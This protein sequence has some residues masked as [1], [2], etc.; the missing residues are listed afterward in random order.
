LRA[1]LDS[2]PVITWR[3]AANGYV[4]ELNERY[5]EYTGSTPEEVRGRRWKDYIHPD[6]LEK[7]VNIGIEYV[8]A[9]E[10][11]DS[12]ARIRRF[13]GEYRWFLHRPA[14]VR[15]ETGTIVAWCGAAIDIEELNRAQEA[16]R[17]SEAYSAEA[18]RLSSM[19]VFAADIANDEHFWSDETRR[20]LGY[21][22]DVRP[23]FDLIHQ[24][25]HP[26][27][28]AIFQYE[29]Q[30]STRGD[31]DH[32]YEVRLLMPDGQIKYLHV[33]AQRVEYENGK[34]ELVGALMDITA[35]RQNEHA[36]KE[37]RAALD[38]TPIAVWSSGS[39]GL[40]DFSNK[41]WLAYLGF[42]AGEVLGARWTAALHPD[43]AQSHLAAW[44]ECVENQIPFQ[45]E[46]RF[47]RFD[48]EYRWFLVDAVPHRDANGKVV[49]WHG[50]CIDIEDRK[51]A[52]MALRQSEAQLAA[53]ERESRLTL[54]SIPVITWR[55]A[56][57]GYVQRINK[58][59]FEYTGST[60]DESRGRRWKDYV[61]PDDIDQLVAIGEEYVASGKSIDCKARVR[62]FDGEYRWF[63]FRPAPARDDTG[64]IVGW[65]G[66]IIDIEDQQRAEEAVAASERNLQ[67]TIDTIPALAWSAP[68]DGTADFLNQHYLD[69]VGLSPEQAR[70]W[71]WTAAVHPDDMNGLAAAWQAIMASG[72]AGEAEARLRRFD[73]QYRWVLFRTHP[74][75]DESGN[76]VKWYGVN[77][78][79]E[80]RKRAETELRSN[81]QRYRELFNSVPVALLEIDSKRR[82]QML[83]DLRRGGVTD[84]EAYLDAHPDFERRAIDT[85]IIKEVNHQMVEMFGVRDAEALVGQSTARLLE[86]TPGA[87]RRGT[88]SRFKGEKLFQHELKLSTAAGRTVDVLLTVARPDVNRN[89]LALTDVTK[90]KAAEDA[91]RRSEA[92]LAK[93]QEVSL[94]G[95]FHLDSATQV[96]TWSAE[97][98][99]IYEIEP[100]TPPT[101]ELIATRYHPEDLAIIDNVAEQSRNAVMNF[102]YEHRLLMP[103]GSVKYVH[104]VANG[105]RNSD[106]RLEYFGAAQDVTAQRLSEQALTRLQTDFAR[107]ARIS[108][109]GEL[110]ASIAHEVNQPL[111]AIRTNSETALR[112]LDR[113]EP[114]VAKARELIRRNVDVA[115]R[116]ADIVAR[117]REMAAGRIPEHTTL[118]LHEVIEESIA[119]LRN[120]LQ[121]NAISVALGLAPAPP[122]VTGDRVQLQQVVVNLTVNAVHAMVEAAATRR[123]LLIR[124]ELTDS[125]TLS[126][127][128]ED[129]GPGIDPGVLDH[130]FD[131]FVTTKDAGMGMGLPVSRSIIEAHGGVIR[132]DNNSVLGG[133]RFSFALP[134]RGATAH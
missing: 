4:E 47:L 73:G 74:L 88:V 1:A 93:G 83:D 133:A 5:F 126:C 6:D 37:L 134:V 13:D 100:G 36:E 111:G 62:R 109:L 69:Y 68:P 44:R 99:R 28:L 129:S 75:R 72:K 102:D 65:Y 30:R 132:A 17:R 27:D 32:D 82:T 76:I 127:S 19:G 58:R 10:P 63:L 3:S 108:M 122:A 95:T 50:T 98:Y 29:V 86:L 45:H 106:G 130:L 7:H 43:D 41:S 42:T 12:R 20:I 94:T 80:D 70:G 128:F 84:L 66:A 87:L 77:T 46:S 120:E 90:L 39:D 54:D 52:E 15:D 105:S 38:N 79:I 35:R 49:K 118:S 8:A 114:N 31:Q 89:F 123:T 124:T 25:I 85:S 23:S 34:A 2:L 97:L 107:A 115:H 116:A 18:Q 48:G 78:D 117:I 16:L 26:D 21:D 56:A 59:W 9:G 125:D 55:A 96:F 104:V 103:N 101:F 131:S 112:W 81:E 113:E 40:S 14:P 53:A 51:R 11:I 64:N 61:H 24:R 67:L 91:L 71:G 60:P 92:L 121:S 119:F 110:A 22:R 57:N 33:I